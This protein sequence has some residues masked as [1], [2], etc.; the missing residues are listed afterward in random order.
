M[1]DASVL[2]QQEDGMAQLTLNNPEQR[3]A[4][5]NQEIALIFDALDRLDPST[6][7]LQI[8][9]RGPVFCAGANLRQITDGSM[10]GEDFQAMTNRIAAAHCPTIAVLEGNVYGGGAELIFSCDFRLAQASGHLRIPAA[11]VGLCYPID[12][13]ERMTQRLGSALVRRLL[14]TTLPVSFEELHHRSAID[15]LVE[16]GALEA[17]LDSLVTKL[18]SLAPLSIQTMLR[19]VKAVETGT[20]D[21]ASAERKAAA[22]LESED[23][24]E[25]LTAQREKRAP[26]FTGR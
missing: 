1:D 20:L 6:R 13:I 10:R 12:G 23:F 8:R 18:R 14:L 2:F 5:G 17:E 25:G 24:K 16:E 11:L 19:T 3:N 9:S 15:Y 4:I 7:V 22:C 26:V 21:R